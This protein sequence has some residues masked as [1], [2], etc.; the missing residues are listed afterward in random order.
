[1]PETQTFLVSNSTEILNKTSTVW[2]MCCYDHVI[3]CV[4]FCVKCPRDRFV[5]HHAAEKTASTSVTYAC[6]SACSFTRRCICQ[7]TGYGVC[8]LDPLL[9]CQTCFNIRVTL[10]EEVKKTGHR[11]IADLPNALHQ[12]HCRLPSLASDR[13]RRPLRT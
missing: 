4:C 3:M 11:L 12:S 7:F 13:P 6:S 5:I 2:S 10:G 1:M 9:A 8:N